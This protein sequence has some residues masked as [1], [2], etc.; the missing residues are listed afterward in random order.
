L[1]G[2]REAHILDPW[3]NINLTEQSIGRVIRTGSHLHLPPQE[4]NVAVYQYAATLADRESIDLTIYKICEK[5]AIK[6]GVVEKILKENAFDCNL[7]KDV[8]IYDEERYNQLIPLKTSH[9]KQ[10]KV[11]LADMAYSRSCFYMKDCTFKCSGNGNDKALLQNMQI[12]IHIPIMKFNY[13]KEVDEYKNLIIQLMATTFNIKIDNLRQYLKKIIYGEQDIKKI[14]VK[15]TKK[16][17]QQKQQKQILNKSMSMHSGEEENVWEDEDA[18]TSAIEEIINNDVDV[19]ITDKFGRRGK[20]VLSGEYLRFIPEGNLEPNMSIQKQSMKI[21]NLKTEVDLKTYI[22]KLGEEQKHLVETE[23]LNYEDIL[24]STIEVIEKVFYGIYQKEYKFNVKIKFEEIVDLIFSKLVYQYK[25]AIIKNILEKIVHGIKLS[26]NENKFENVIKNH[27]VYLND[28]FP[29]SK[30]EI[31]IKKSIYGFIIQNENK[32]EL[33]ILNSNKEFEKNQGNLR[34][35]I[36]QRRKI[37]TKTPNNKI[38][39]YLKYEKGREIPLFK[40]TDI[41]KGE[42]KSLI[43]STCTTKKTNEIKKHINKLDDKIL[44]SKTLLMNKNVLCND[45]EILLKRNDNMKN[46][47]KKWYYTPEE[48][49]IYFGGFS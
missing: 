47:G 28:V 9:N 35:V 13:D 3:H 26:I 41:T 44:K 27:I 11:S 23:E 40:I 45:I 1:F 36:E 32:L 16:H 31:D 15:K 10:I 21:P 17:T 24:V 20:I 33:Y 30:P 34:K 18:F 37:L 25:L 29:D 43:G 4:R 46:D 48:Y 14:E 7:N 22:T 12:P 42:K 8:N 38:Y 39:G 6:A 5:K 19:V 2:Y 49:E